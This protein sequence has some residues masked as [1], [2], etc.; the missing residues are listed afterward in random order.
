LRKTRSLGIEHHIYF[1]GLSRK[2]EGKP[3]FKKIA[4]LTL[5]ALAVLTISAFG[6]GVSGRLVIKGSDTM[7]PLANQWA[8]DFQKKNPRA[9]VSVTGGGS[10]VGITALINGTCDIATSSRPIEPKEVAA[11]RSRNF[12]PK[13]F[14]VAI[15]G[16]AVVVHP[17]NPIKSLT[18]DQVRDIYTGKITNWSQLGVKAG[19]IVAVGRDT[20]SGTYKFFQEDVLKGAKYRA[21][22]I[23]L[24]STNAIATTVSQD[25]GAI[26]Y[27]GIAYAKSFAKRVKVLPISFGK[28]K[29]AIYPSDN[30]IRSRQYP[31]SRSLFCYTRGNPT[32]LAKAFL[33]FVM[34][35][36][37]QAGVRKVGYV[38]IK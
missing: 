21:D 29:P 27:I 30:A 35:P 28:G 17:S 14:P 12:V 33:D 37:G 8:E 18:V 23:S 36:E 19:R 13:E 3:M 34:S 31:I 6:A 1:P 38:P 15:D 25:K 7:L 10:G 32:G 16:I 9:T 26:G 2:E 20:S 5:S 4:A 22:M 11:A 24:P